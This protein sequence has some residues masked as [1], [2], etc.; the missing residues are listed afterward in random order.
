MK[1]ILVGTDLS[2]AGNRAVQ[3]AVSMAHRTG[4]ALRI[5]HVAPPKR[6]LTGLWRVDFRTLSAVHRHAAEAVK[7]LAEALDANR[8]IDLSTGVIS[9]A[10]SAQLVRA[11]LEFDADLL[12]VGARGEHEVRTTDITLGGTATRLLSTTPVPLFIARSIVQHPSPVLAA[13]D[14]SPLSKDVLT[15][16]RANTGEGEVLTVFHAYDV[17]F[18]SRL[19]AYGIAKETIDLYSNEDLKEREEAIHALLGEIGGTRGERVIVRRGDAIDSLFACIQEVNPGLIVVGQHTRRGR[20]GAKRSGS[21]ARH[22][23]FFAAANVLVVPPSRSPLVK[24]GDDASAD[25]D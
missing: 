5:V 8:Q 10:A 22:V 24:P 23:A 17:P 7:H 1:R 16:A 20:S 13:V 12:V 25:S 3:V 11:A 6:W 14:L 21:V 15:W 19:E 18:A 2:P 9:G 4:A